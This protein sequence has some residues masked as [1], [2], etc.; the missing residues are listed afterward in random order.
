MSRDKEIWIDSPSLAGIVMVS[1]HGRVK[2]LSFSYKGPGGTEIT[3]PE[4]VLIRKR[5][6]YYPKLKARVKGEWKSYSFHRLIAEAFIPNPKSLPCVNHIDGDKSNCHP[7]NLEWCTHKQNIRHAL[8]SG[9]TNCSV[10]VMASFGGIG[11][12]FPS[13]QSAM[14]RTGI[15]KPCICAAAKKRQKTA[16]GMIWDY[17]K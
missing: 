1:S 9:L 15:S 16:G 13:M 10:S 5:T 12:W 7:N 8:E 3:R 4:R 17:V 2:M 11:F 14:E 6:H